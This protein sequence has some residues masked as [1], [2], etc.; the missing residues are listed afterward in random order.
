VS[1][2]RAIARALGGEV[3]SRSQVLAPGPGHRP[4]DRSLSVWLLPRAPDGFIVHSHAG[5]DWRACRNYVAQCIGID[6]A[7]ES[8]CAD[9]PPPVPVSWDGL[10][11][12][13]K[14]AIALEIFEEAQN[15]LG[16]AVELY[17]KNR[18]LE[19]PDGAAGHAIRFHPHC[20]FAGKRTPAMVCLVRDLS[21]DAPRGIH[22]TALSFNGSKVRLEGKDRL[23]L[24]SVS[25]GAIKITPDPEVTT[26]L[27]VG[28]GVESTLSL[29]LAPEFGP[30]PV[31]SLMSSSGLE[32]LPVLAGIECLWVAVD[33]D[34]AGLKASRVVAERWAAERREVFLI[35]PFADQAD[36]NDLAKGIGP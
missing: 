21:S 4:K 14:L 26:C 8:P 6:R 22:R 7:P 1:D 29:R 31:W 19:L 13:R 35:R 18:G 30:S 15:P 28:E 2:L 3:V 12:A 10:D 9:R 5:D 17:L 24:G 11:N 34:P 20:P 32:G 33:N 25:G 16:T 23:A 36:L 27:G